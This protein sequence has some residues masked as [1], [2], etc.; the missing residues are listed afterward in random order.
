MS[1]TVALRPA[2]RRPGCSAAPPARSIWNN[3]LVVATQ[4]R[5]PVDAAPRL[6]PA[7]VGVTVLAVLETPTPRSRAPRSGLPC[8]QAG[9][10]SPTHS[11]YGGRRVALFLFGTLMDTDVMARVLGRTFRADELVA[12][13]LDGWRRVRALNA[14]YPLLLPD[15]D[16][17]VDGVLFVRPSPR[18]LVRIR[19]FESEEYEARAA[20]VRTPDGAAVPAFVFLALDKV[21]ATDGEPWCLER[22]RRDHK[23]EFLVRCDAWMA[24]CPDLVEAGR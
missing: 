14:T 1:R 16:G 9:P 13:S 5:L 10:N 4:P 11:S 7:H 22:W 8:A 6:T 2:T 21:F 20:T 17:A 23:A 19:H 18:D 3:R 12:A 24:D 15:P